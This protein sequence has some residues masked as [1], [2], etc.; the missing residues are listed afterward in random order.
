MVPSASAVADVV[1]AVRGRIAAYRAQA[2]GEQNTKA[3]LIVPL[4][5]ALGWN[6]EDLREVH[7]EYR[8]RPADKPVDYAL[9]INGAPRLFVEAKA[10]GENLDDRRWANQVMGYA[11]VAGVRW[12]VL[13]NG[14]EYRLYNAG[15]S[16][17]VEEK[18]FR[19]VR[20][21]EEATNPEETLALISKE[22]VAELEALWQE[23][24]VGRRVRSTL[25]ALF[26]PEADEAVVRL[27]RRRLPELTRK[28]IRGALARLR[29]GP[30]PETVSVAG[31]RPVREDR[32][33][34][35]GRVFGEG[36]P[37]NKV[38]LGDLI[39]AGFMRPPV[40]LSKRYKGRLLTARIE[41]DG[42][43]TF[44]DVTY[45]SLSIAASMARRSVIG[46]PPGRAY[47]QTNGWTFW[48]YRDRDGE[49]R[50]VD[51]LRRQ[52]W[53]SRTSRGPSER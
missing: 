13:T 33:G 9:L 6:V 28:Q 7:L 17:P 38:T 30:V 29:F 39:E 44:G 51:E 26:T 19:T 46:V 52:L 24:F 25:E 34:E 15:A 53:G 41:P 4:L 16:V 3:T 37:W 5:R 47:P 43:V 21:S 20:I 10:L 31:S 2:I 42:R 23:D 36:T 48:Q 12:V 11:A 1:P 27:L 14:D 50:Y 45:G 49:L 40:E 8:R 18:L 32:V 22:S 35:S